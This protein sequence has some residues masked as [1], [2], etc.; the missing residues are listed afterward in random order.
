MA[1]SGSFQSNAITTVTNNNFPRYLIVE[2]SAE[3]SIANNSS[4]VSY[5]VKA[6]GVRTSSFC[7]CGPITITL[8]GH[9]LYSTTSRVQIYSASTLA[10][11]KFVVNHNNETGEAWMAASIQAAIY[12][13]YINSTYSGTEY[14]DTIP[15]NAKLLTAPSFNDE[16]NPTI[17][18]SNP[19][20]NSVTSLQACIS[21]TGAKD[22][23]PYRD[24]SKTG[25]SYTFSL[26]DAERK[27]L[28]QNTTAATGTRSVIFY[29][30]TVLGNTTLHST[31]VKTLSLVD[32]QPQIVASVYDE[33]ERTVEL[34]G[35]NTKFIR[36]FSNAR[37]TIG[38]MPKK[39]ATIT[40]YEATNGSKKLTTSTGVIQGVED[41]TFT[42]SVTD[43]RGLGVSLVTK[44]TVIPY[45]TFTCKMTPRIFLSTSDS[46]KAKL[47]IEVEGTYYNGSFGAV[48]N[49]ITITAQLK[50]ESGNLSL[51]S[52]VIDT[53]ITFNGSSFQGSKTIDNLDYREAY[54]VTL[55]AGDALT[56]VTIV[57]D[58]L[59]ANPI[60]DWGANDFSFN[61]PISIEGYPVADYPIECG[62][63]AMGSNGTWYWTK[64]K[65]GK[66]ECYGCRNYGNM[67]VSMPYDG[68]LYASETFT[69]DFPSGLFVATPEIIDIQFRNAG[70]YYSEAMVVKGYPSLPLNSESVLPSKTTT[71]N[72][73]VARWYTATLPQVNI[74]F[75][76]IGRWK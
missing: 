71:G 11:G 49:S 68:G 44:K 62:T 54:T 67:S 55:V 51:H 29:V 45:N 42:F 30:K 59:R 65:S 4:T 32:F 52:F 37:Y 33:N 35:D 43:S 60:F 20:G 69:Q 57:S 75:N 38:G 24:I 64:W 48:D 61:V 6:S 47:T 53:D 72:F 5:T 63:A 16:E 31:L 8:G 19:A 36:Y 46:T 18:Y 14:L 10:T 12:D 21:F 34:T 50:T 2:W 74:G 27:I 28:R 76:I 22:D 70:T 40:S 73:F 15:R 3:Q 41:E 26:T 66:A 56:S 39:E 23:I 1:L 58:P 25:T 7:W 9:T 13:G 17:T